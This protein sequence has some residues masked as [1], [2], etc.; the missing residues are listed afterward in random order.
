MKNLIKVLT[1]FFVLTM[2][3]LPASAK[4]P[5][6]EALKKSDLSSKAYISISFKPMECDNKKNLK[7]NQNTPM[8]AA[9]IQ[10][11]V[12]LIPSLDTLGEKYEF[13]TTLYKSKLDNSVYLKLGADPYLTSK[14]L[15]GMINGLDRYKIKTLKTFYID[16]S[17]LDSSEWGDDWLKEDI[18]SSATPKFGAYNLDKNLI[19]VDVNPTTKGA[20]AEIE[21]I[22]FYPITFV[23]NVVTGNAN[24]IKMEYGSDIS[25]D[26]IIVTGT[27]ASDYAQFIPILHPR[28]Y[29]IL[30]L[31]NVLRKQKIGYYGNFNRCKLP[32]NI[33]VVSQVKHNLKFA[34]QDALKNSNN[35]VTETVF[36]LA[37]GKYAQGTGSF[38][39]ATE[40]MN[41][42]YSKQNIDMTGIKLVDASGVSHN[43]TLT[44][45]FVTNVLVKN[46]Q[47]K[48]YMA[49]PTVGTFANR[50]LYFKDNIK[51]KSGTLNGVSSA[52]GYI[53]AKSGKSYAFCIIVHDPN[54][55]GSDKKAFEEY[56]LRQAFSSL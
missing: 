47:I 41:N 8:T 55:T 11:L 14:D 1:L 38:Y 31:E 2:L 15:R 36:K 7:L 29:F 54:T 12:T 40:M 22:I 56:M 20:P 44:A 50:M 45:D 26:S 19:E 4:N 37:G 25:P 10:K 18:L 23:N 51:I 13:K 28:R 6:N 32:Q 53:K 42:Y 39:S 9:S 35:M 17:I 5:I 52:A 21:T 43:N 49:F 33:G 30:R 27:V 16:D 34:L 24:S 46:P 48:D 3:S